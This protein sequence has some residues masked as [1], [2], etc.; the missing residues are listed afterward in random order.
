MGSSVKRLA[1]S[2]LVGV[3]HNHL[4]LTDMIVEIIYRKTNTCWESRK[5]G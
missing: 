3:P 2:T 4:P 1:G 5:P